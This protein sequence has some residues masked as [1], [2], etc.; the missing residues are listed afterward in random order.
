MRPTAKQLHGFS[1]QAA[2]CFGKP[3]LG[4]RYTAAGYERYK[5]TSD[6]CALCGH[7]A[8]NTHHQP[9]RQFFTLATPAGIWQ[10]RPALF[11]L[12]GSGTT[13]CHGLI[14][15][16]RIQVRW[17]WDAPQY[18]TAWWDGE[19]LKEYGEHNPELYNFGGW[20]F[21][22]PNGEEY[23]RTGIPKWRQTC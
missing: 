2:E 12:C 22:M 17:V 15:A 19:L 16:N 7:P 20:V 8:T 14:E 6:R 21:T 13:G 1:L 18:E 9:Y 11:V 3:H 5:R 4:A 10:L 23:G